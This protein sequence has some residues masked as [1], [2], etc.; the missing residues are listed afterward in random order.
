MTAAVGLPCI[1]QRKKTL[2]ELIYNLLPKLHF[3]HRLNFS[4]QALKDIKKRMVTSARRLAADNIRAAQFSTRSH[5]TNTP[6]LCPTRLVNGSYPNWNHQ[7]G[8]CRYTQGR[9]KLCVMELNYE[10]LTYLRLRNI[11][12]LNWCI[13]N[14]RTLKAAM[15]LL[16]LYLSMASK[17]T[18]HCPNQIVAYFPCTFEYF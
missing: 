13:Y 17:S 2:M 15:V 12:S 5:M 16:H 7:T 1:N 10:L 9:A 11:V 8:S 14:R 18:D 3:S 6:G 4:L